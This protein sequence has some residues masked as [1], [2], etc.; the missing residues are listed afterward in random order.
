LIGNTGSRRVKQALRYALK[1]PDHDPRVCLE[2]Y[3]A[4]VFVDAVREC[5][6]AA[7]CQQTKDEV[8]KGGT[9]LV[10][11]RDRVFAVYSD[12]SYL[13]GVDAFLAL[14]CGASLA[15]GSL[16]STKGKPPRTRVRMALEAAEH[17]SAGV[18]RPFMVR[19]MKVT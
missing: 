19:S 14:G 6:K 15:L 12:Y 16:H 17:F 2:R 3:I 11:Y 7:G 13:V 9:F 1:V 10:G 18:R 5:L 8:D 4:T